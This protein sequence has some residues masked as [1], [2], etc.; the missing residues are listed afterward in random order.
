M[1]E[2]TKSLVLISFGKLAQSSR[3]MYNNSFYPATRQL[4]VP[5]KVK[6]KGGGRWKNHL[7]NTE[8]RS[9]KEGFYLTELKDIYGKYVKS[10]YEL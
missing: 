7:G 10:G 5:V 9:V 1:E 8:I 6:V 3:K 4:A 2:E